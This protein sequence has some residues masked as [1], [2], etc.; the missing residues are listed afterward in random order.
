LNVKSYLDAEIMPYNAL[1]P[2]LE[3]ISRLF[4]MFYLVEFCLKFDR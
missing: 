4:E 2:K 1:K 3:Q